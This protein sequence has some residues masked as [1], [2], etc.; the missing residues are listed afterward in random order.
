MYTWSDITE[1][2]AIV[3]EHQDNIHVCDIL[4]SAPQLS[5]CFNI[6][7]ATY[8]HIENWRRSWAQTYRWAVHA[9]SVALL[10]PLA[11]EPSSP[12]VPLETQARVSDTACLLP[13]KTRSLL[14]VQEA[15]RPGSLL[16]APPFP[17][18]VSPGVYQGPALITPTHSPLCTTQGE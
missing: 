13:S 5:Q 1:H 11:Q 18:P 15:P 6:H 10:S 7:T 8:I 2:Y 17:P 9:A 12:L 16:H 4:I 3:A 14:L